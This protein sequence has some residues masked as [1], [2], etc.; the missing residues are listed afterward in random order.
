MLKLKVENPGWGEEA[1]L[2]AKS[3]LTVFL[4]V[5]VLFWQL[6]EKLMRLDAFW[7]F[8]SN[9]VMVKSTVSFPSFLA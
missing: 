7:G 1:R 2:R 8:Q 4:G 9:A 3:T 6:Q 5:I